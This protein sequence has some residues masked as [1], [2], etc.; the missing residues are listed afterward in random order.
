MFTLLL[1]AACSA[2]SG[3]DSGKADDTECDR[4]RDRVD[5]AIVDAHELG[6]I[7]VMLTHLS[8]AF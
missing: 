3:D 6:C 7:L 1:L 4:R 5:A 8:S 2:P